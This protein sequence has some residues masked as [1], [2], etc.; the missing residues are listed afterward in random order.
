MQLPVYNT[1]VKWMQFFDENTGYIA[2]DNGQILK[3]LD[4]GISFDLCSDHEIWLKSIYF[5]D[6]SAGWIIG[7][8]NGQGIL[9]T[10]SDGGNTWDSILVSNAEAI[11]AVDFYGEDFG[12]LVGDKGTVYHTLN[13][14][15]DWNKKSGS[16]TSASLEDIHFIDQYTGWISCYDPHV[17][18]K[19]DDGGESWTEIHDFGDN[20]INDLAFADENMGWGCSGNNLL[21]TTNG[22]VSWDS[23]F[24]VSHWGIVSMYAFDANKIFVNDDTCIYR[25]LDGGINWDIVTICDS[26]V[27]YSQMT[28]YENTGWIVASKGGWWSYESNIYRSDDGGMNWYL[29]NSSDDYSRFNFVIRD[30]GFAV[31]SHASWGGWMSTHIDKTT[32]GGITWDTKFSTGGEYWCPYFHTIEFRDENNGWAIS[33]SYALHSDDGGETWEH[34]ENPPNQGHDIIFINE[35]TGWLI[36]DHSLWKYSGGGMVG[37]QDGQDGNSE[38]TLSVYPNPCSGDMHLR[39]SIL[40]TRDAKLEIYSTNGVLVKTLKQEVQQAGEY[41]QTYDL[42]DLPTGIYFIRLQA[43]VQ[44]ETSKII[45]LK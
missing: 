26:S 11:Y 31:A 12:W 18:L 7:N 33:N 23:I 28:F 35:N 1:G 6:I 10:T 37:I 14:G 34:L 21:K 44:T 20:F 5:K 13:G 36:N 29:L 39:Y 15:S 17:L 38:N 41:E 27:R 8:N 2:C 32:D 40:E 24:S 42:S 16:L 9:K 19:T 3:T 45:I 25:S 22:G 4:G 30:T 43:G